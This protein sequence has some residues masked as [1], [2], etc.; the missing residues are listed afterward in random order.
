MDGVATGR[1]EIEWIGLGMQPPPPPETATVDEIHLV[2]GTIELGPLVRI[3]ATEV[4]T[5]HDSF[6]RDSVQWIHLAGAGSAM[7][8]PKAQATQTP[9]S[10]GG[11]GA[12]EPTPGVARTPP[13]SPPGPQHTPTP[14]PSTPTPRPT[15]VSTRPPGAPPVTPCPADKPLGGWLRAEEESVV[16][17]S[18]NGFDRGCRLTVTAALRFRLVPAA[19]EI[20][21]WE[22]ILWSGFAAERIDFEVS[23]AGCIDSPGDDLVCQAPPAHV[24]DTVVLGR[25]TPAL[26]FQRDPAADGYFDFN[27]VKPELE[28]LFPDAIKD[29][30]SV[31]LECTGTTEGGSQG[32]LRYGVTGPDIGPGVVPVGPQTFRIDGT[33]CAEP[34]GEALRREC[35]T[36]PERSAVI[37]FSGE[38]TWR[39]PT[40]TFDGPVRTDYRWEICCG[41][42]ER[43]AGAPPESSRT[44]CPD[45]SQYE[46]QADLRLRQ[47]QALRN[48]LH[49]EWSEFQSSW[50]QAAQLRSD[51]DLV[52]RSCAL[53]EIGEKLVDFV[54]SGG[55]E[56][57]ASFTAL[58]GIVNKIAQGDPSWVLAFAGSPEGVSI[59]GMFDT[60][61]STVSGIESVGKAGT[62]EGMQEKLQECAGTG[63]IADAVWQGAQ[64]Y[65]HNLKA[66]LDMLPAIQ[67]LVTTIRDTDLDYWTWRNR[68]YQACLDSAA[69]RGEPPSVCDQFKPPDAPGP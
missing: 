14:G 63:L 26:G 31:P 5:L 65:L 6:P 48:Q 41:C 62:I 17:G 38:V 20:A 57:A 10:G 58:A 32:L 49:T 60:I 23:S 39:S 50:H 69:C 12:A 37:P 8:S 11:G 29:A 15:R 67:H 33:R 52:I 18:F 55:G 44:P 35:I 25:A 21:G 56:A 28:T 34:L 40:E 53:W 43:P 36:H 19:P 30:V 47:G 22:V 51:Y 2:D 64:D 66:A 16:G 1:A 9:G 4:A 54:A 46:A 45:F 3:T 59:Q 27:P 42:G 24:R 13:P 61:N 68:L 7:P